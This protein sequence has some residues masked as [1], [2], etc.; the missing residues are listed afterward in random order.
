M[1]TDTPNTT[2]LLIEDNPADQEMTRRALS[3]ASPNIALE[4]CDDGEQALD[5]LLRRDVY[6]ADETPTPQ[7]I[8]L[9]LNLPKLSGKEIIRCV[10]GDD[11]LKHMPLIVLTTSPAEEDILESYRLGCNS[12]LIKPNRFDEF[13][14]VMQQLTHYWLSS[15][16]LPVK[17]G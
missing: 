8:L 2:I 6:A 11:E 16:H 10:R 14:S 5:F 15:V 9:D 3:K 13:V 4:V 17:R 1:S 7:L 12:Y